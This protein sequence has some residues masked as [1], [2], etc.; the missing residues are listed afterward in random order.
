MTPRLPAGRGIGFIALTFG[1]IGLVGLV[2]TLFWLVGFKVPSLLPGVQADPELVEQE[3]GLMIMA[4]L[5]NGLMA[6]LLA[7]FGLGLLRQWGPGWVFMLGRIWAWGML[8]FALFGAWVGW[9]NMLAIDGRM[10]ETGTGELLASADTLRMTA[11]MGIVFGAALSWGVAFAL[12]GWIGFA[13]KRWSTYRH[14]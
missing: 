2:V 12:L 7:V 13:S 1:V 14:E 10:Q 4:S 6:G 9:L 3:S 11:L 5:L 8:P